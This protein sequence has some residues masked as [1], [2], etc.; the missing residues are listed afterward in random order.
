M[1]NIKEYLKNVYELEKSLYGQ[2]MLLTRMNKQINIINGYKEEEHD[3]YKEEQI[4]TTDDLGMI[5]G[6][7]MIGAIIG[8]IIGVFADSPESFIASIIG[9][10]FIAFVGITGLVIWICIDTARCNKENKE[11]IE[12]MNEEI[13]RRNEQLRITKKKQ[14]DIIQAEYNILYTEYK[15]TNDI[16]NSYYEKNIIFVKYR[17]FVA[18]SSFY[19]YFMSG[20]CVAFEGHEGAY[21]IYE[22]EI[23]LNVVIQKL[24]DVIQKLDQIQ[25][26]QYM[27]YSAIQE[28]NKKITKLSQVTSDVTNKLQDISQN[29]EISAYYNGITALNTTAI[30][31]LEFSQI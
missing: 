2:K 31:W 23:R 24:D 1:I 12:E 17:N 18:V 8:A 4:L 30:K 22:N 5:G 13:D 27:L 28:C 15:H 11:N 10:A 14:I 7:T 29:A 19:E 3:I 20:R 6:V 21:N 26:N 16:L 9:V 25:D